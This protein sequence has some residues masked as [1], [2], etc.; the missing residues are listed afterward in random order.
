MR[1]LVSGAACRSGSGRGEGGEDDVGEMGEGDGG[2]REK[3]PGI[4]AV[5]TA[6]AEV[7]DDVAEERA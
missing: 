4:V 3:E 6:V 7:A 1:T 5:D 2:G